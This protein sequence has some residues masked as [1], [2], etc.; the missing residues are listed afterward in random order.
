VLGAEPLERRR[1]VIAY[2]SNACPAQLAHKYDSTDQSNVVP[3][4][5]A[6]IDGMAIGYSDHVTTYGAVPANAFADPGVQTEVFVAWLDPEQLSRL[7]GSEGRN[8]RRQ[9]LDLDSH[10]LR[11]VDGPRLNGADIYLST[12]GLFTVDGVAPGM[13]GVQTTYAAGPLLTQL[14]VR[15]LR[16]RDSVNP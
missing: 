13:A 6:W 3:M 14:E 2:G 9:S 5:R 12:H 11:V 4:S 10:Q 8:Y 15:R 7:D 1:A 16:D